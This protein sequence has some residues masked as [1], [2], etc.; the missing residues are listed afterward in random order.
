MFGMLAGSFIFGVLADKV[1]RKPTLIAGAMFLSVSGSVSAIFTSSFPMFA[2]LRFFSGMG[3]MGT[4]LITFT[5]AIEYVGSS[6]RELT[7]I[8]IE[9]PFASGGLLV[10]ILSL[11]ESESPV[12]VV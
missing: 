1:G 8:L 10:G 9:V 2:A 12:A 6:S 7:G 3:H 11:S 5:L 4:F